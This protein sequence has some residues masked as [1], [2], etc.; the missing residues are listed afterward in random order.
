MYF[1]WLY[2]FYTE[3]VF[4]LNKFYVATAFNNYDTVTAI[5]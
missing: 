5:G 3:G 1:T 2:H 4:G